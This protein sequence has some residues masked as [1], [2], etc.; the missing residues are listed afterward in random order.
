MATSQLCDSSRLAY[1]HHQGPVLIT[2]NPPYQTDTAVENRVRGIIRAETRAAASLD[3]FTFYKTYLDTNVPLLG[4]QDDFESDDDGY[5]CNLGAA[6]AHDTPVDDAQPQARC[7]TAAYK[8]AVRLANRSNGAPLATIIEQGSYST[9][10][11]HGSLLSVGR[12][13]SI[14][15]A[16]NTSPNRGS[17]RRS[18]SLDE[19]ALHDIQEDLAREYDISTVAVPHA[20]LDEEHGAADPASGTATPLTSYRFELQ[21]SPSSHSGDEL[22]DHDSRGVKGFI[23]GVLQNVRG[24]SR[25]RSRSSSMTHAP[26]MEHRESPPSTCGSSPQ[27]G[28]Q[29]QGPEFAHLPKCSRNVSTR[30]SEGAAIPP[31]PEDQTRNRAISS[32]AIELSA[33][34]HP[35]LV[36][37]PSYAPESTTIFGS[38]PP[39]L[40]YRAATRSHEQPFSTPVV[41][42]GTRDVARG[43]GIAQASTSHH[44][45]FDTSA[46]YTFDGAPVYRGCPSSLREASSAREVFTSQNTSFCSTMSTSYSG[47][48]LGVDLDLQHDF[49][50]PIRR[51]Q[52]PPTPVWFTPQMVE[53][54][55]QASFSESP[56]SVKTS[57]PTHAPCRSITSSALTSLLPIAAASGIV[58]PN[59]N[60]P[61]I[62]FYSPS[63]NLIQP[64]SSSPQG[65]SP[66]EYGGSPTVT[67]SYYNKQNANAASPSG[68]L[69][70][71]P[72][73][74][75][76]TTPP[77]QKTPLPPHLRHHHNYR[78][79]E[80]SQISSCES[81]ITPK[82]PL[83]GCDGIVRENSL[84][85]RSGIFYPHGKDRAHRSTRLIMHNLKA[86]AKFYKAR[87]L[88][89]A[90][91][92]SFAP[93]IPKGRTLQK[94][95]V[96]SYN[97]Y[98][99]NPH[100]GKTTTQKGGY[101]EDVL[102]PL[103]AHALRVCFCQPYD[104]AGE[105]TRATAA[106]ACMAGEPL[107][108]KGKLKA[109]QDVK[110]VE[111]SLPNAR[112]VGSGRR[113]EGGDRKRAARRDSAVN[114]TTR[115]VSNTG[116]ARR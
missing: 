107:P 4:D 26:I 31:T 64:E 94:R 15:A 10:N 66:S 68:G 78:H 83:K 58:R 65:T 97:T 28:Q 99:R 48:V 23:R 33:R 50:H 114:S 102:G 6:A 54:E 61:K 113:S 104:G 34:A 103:A 88:A 14:K 12:F 70:I 106:G 69:P 98:A 41:H 59:Y 16:E 76:M 109:D 13:P 62:S 90:A 110:D 74:V 116:M 2:S 86:E 80:M 5:T 30:A 91:A 32:S 81:S 56:E 96:H 111:R 52:S 100:T 53:L 79:P 1:G 101:R 73:L 51:S 60:T 37:S 8:L 27:L 18:R 93:S 39:A 45:T 38:L 25:T 71:R 20:R 63:G 77:T 3:P 21:Q 87:F 108:A 24:V 85:P 47:T 7:H 55:R 19:K 42:A 75:P 112:V 72:P 105:S 49:S 9:L 43:D 46:R 40:P 67:T 36:Q 17:R 92:Q 57:V 95:H 35:P 89:L 44:D 82:G 115:R 11:S 29:D 22:F 84:T